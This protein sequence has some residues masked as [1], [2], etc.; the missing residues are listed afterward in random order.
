MSEI[1]S[2]YATKQK[3]S[4]KQKIGTHVVKGTTNTFPFLSFLFFY[5]NKNQFLKA[6][7]IISLKCSGLSIHYTGDN[8]PI[9]C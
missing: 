4:N 1:K 3:G 8:L 6:T 2:V 9:H 5:I 7:S